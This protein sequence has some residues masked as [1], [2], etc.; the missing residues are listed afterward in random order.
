MQVRIEM[1][2]ATAWILWAIIS[3]TVGYLAA[4]NVAGFGV[5]ADY[6]KAFLWG[7]G[8]QTAGTQ[9]QTLTP[10]SIGSTIGVSIPK[11]GNS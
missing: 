5:M 4:V 2:S 7:L 6:L 10:T 8:L 3:A 1:V 9:L 11:I